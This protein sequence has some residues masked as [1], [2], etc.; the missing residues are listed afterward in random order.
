MF[1]N[2]TNAVYKGDYRIEIIFANGKSGIVDFDG[3]SSKG[4]IFQ[5]FQDIEFFKKFTIEYGTL[6]W[7]NGDIDIAPET[8]YE[9][10]TTEII[11]FVKILA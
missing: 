10:A 6:C 1:F 2:V 9:K 7:D 5:N 3:Y 8:L 4:E 11:D